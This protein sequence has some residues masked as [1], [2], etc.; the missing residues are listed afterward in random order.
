MVAPLVL[1]ARF[2]A[3]RALKRQLLRKAVQHKQ[4]LAGKLP[5][6]IKRIQFILDLIKVGSLI[7]SLFT[8]GLDGVSLLTFFFTANGELV[9]GIFVPWF[10][11]QAWRKIIIIVLDLLVLFAAL[12]VMFVIMYIHENPSD[13]CALLGGAVLGPIGAGLGW[14]WAQVSSCGL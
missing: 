1:A 14:A 8:G 4:A 2:E 6:K 13:A 10:K 9:A 5:E 11:Q 12:A 7:T 3:Q